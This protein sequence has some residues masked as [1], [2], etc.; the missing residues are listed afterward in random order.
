M[1]EVSTT[2]ELPVEH[3]D[4]YLGYLAHVQDAINRY[5][6]TEEGNQQVLNTLIALEQWMMRVF[7]TPPHKLP[8]EVERRITA[9]YSPDNAERTI[10]DYLDMARD[11]VAQL[12]RG[13]LS[14]EQ[15]A[16]QLNILLITAE[17]T[18]LPP[19]E[20]RGIL[21]GNGEGVTSREYD[22]RLQLLITFLQEHEIFTDDLILIRGVNL[23]SM[24][25]GESYVL[26]EI[27]RIAKQILVCNE[28]GEA[29]FVSERM[30]QRELYFQCT[31][32]EL[33]EHAGIHRIVFNNPEQWQ[34]EIAAAL[35][36]LDEPIGRKINVRDREQCRQAIQEQWTAEQ[37]LA[38]THQE[39]KDM[40][41]HGRKINAI[42]RSIFGLENTRPKGA[43][44]IG[45][46]LDFLELAACIYGED[47]PSIQ[48]LLERERENARALAEL[49][50]D[51]ARWRTFLQERIAAEQWVATNMVDKDELQFFG[52]SVKSI[53][54]IFGFTENNT[55]Y[56]R[57]LHLEVGARIYGENHPTIAP[58]LQQERTNIRMQEELGMGA[59]R[60]R[61][62]ISQ[63]VTPEAWAS[64]SSKE[65]QEFSIHGVKLHLIARVFGV[66]G[67]PLPFA[68][69]LE[70]GTKIYGEE[71]MHAFAAAVRA[72]EEELQHLGTDPELWRRAISERASQEEWV[73]MKDVP[74]RKFSIGGKKP[75]A[76]ARIFGLQG[77]GRSLVKNRVEFLELGACIY[78]KE[79]KLIQAALTTAREE[80]MPFLIAGE[81]NDNPKKQKPTPEQWRAFIQSQF[82]AEQW[83]AGI[84]ERQSL[85]F[86]GTGLKALATIF[87]ISGTNPRAIRVDYLELGAR[88]YGE[89]HPAI[90]SLLLAEREKLDSMKSLGNDPETWKR[91]IREQVTP[92]Q[93]MEWGQKERHQFSAHGKGLSAI[94]TIFGLTGENICSIN[95]SYLEL[96][97]K[98]FGEDDPVLKPMLETSRRITAVLSELGEDQEKWRAE[99]VAKV[100]PEAWIQPNAGA[101]KDVFEVH[102][103]NLETFASIFGVEGNPSSV[104]VVR[105]EL[106]A[107]I[108]G[109]DHPVIRPHLEEARRKTQ[110]ASQLGIDLV[111][112]REA[113]TGMTTAEQ[114]VKMSE[115]DK[116][117][118]RLHGKG[119]KAIA[120][121]LGVQGN[122]IDQ[123]ICFLELG[124]AI[125]GQ[126]NPVIQPL[127]EAARQQAADFQSMGNDSERWREI[128][129]SR[130]T[131]EEWVRWTTVERQAFSV[132]GRKLGAI[133]SIFG[134][135][136]NPYHQRTAH[137]ELGKLIFGAEAIES[138]SM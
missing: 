43:R 65:R 5:T 40:A 104:R 36:R 46:R 113:I 42:A 133:G 45:Y 120:T 15:I 108:Y 26:V 117:G 48:P 102:G 63:R 86:K 131:P 125:F 34:E 8:D 54:K 127:L 123:R 119:L 135:E 106:A 4:A 21:P 98:I 57:L 51:P 101:R 118:F 38:L 17:E 64:M 75:Q 24:M 31:K 126:E 74:R 100:A 18:I 7:G 30:L 52:V 110:E 96:G 90:Q 80:A 2:Q 115:K 12:V 94:A 10:S 49:N 129:Q 69:H 111:A 79:E 11:Q 77:Q 47:H 114:W 85:R 99:I 23:P 136:G 91:L 22:P 83:V 88:I 134:V 6:G 93:W 1:P 39:K 3:Q 105:L 53:A 92:Q 29:T 56:T 13:E 95:S 41:I 16:E 97:A 116:Q 107:K 32:E 137:I 9:T 37:W 130:V 50:N 103:K 138:A 112:W 84:G 61:A 132:G 68:R 27:P 35:F 70:V 67:N 19:D 81:V 82:T 25:R 121:L 122:P 20:R 128:I 28:V 72:H 76:I 66:Q 78:G 33:L 87:G 71:A 59:E 44:P 124:T 109:E 89:S 62:E 73:D 60:W 55:D 58:V 14:P